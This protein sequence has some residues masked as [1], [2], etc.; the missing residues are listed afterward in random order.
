MTSTLSHHSMSSQDI[1]VPPPRKT[2]GRKRPVTP[3][4]V[5]GPSISL[6]VPNDVSTSTRPLA[7]SSIAGD[8]YT[9][10]A[11]GLLNRFSAAS[12]SWRDSLA[13]LD[14]E[15]EPTV[16][17]VRDTYKRGGMFD[18]SRTTERQ[19][20]SVERRAD[21]DEDEEEDDD[22]DA[23]A[24]KAA[25]ERMRREARGEAV[26]SSQIPSHP[27]TANANAITDS[28]S[29]KTLRVPLPLAPTTRSSSLSSAPP[30]S[31]PSRQP[32]VLRLNAV[33]EETMPVR[34]PGTA[35][36]SGRVGRV[37]VSDDEEDSDTDMGTKTRP[38]R[39]LASAS[40]ESEENEDDHI[41]PL[42]EA[43]DPANAPDAER[44]P[45][46]S[47]FHQFFDSLQDEDRDDSEV[48]QDQSQ[49]AD[50][51]GL[52]DDEELQIKTGKTNIKP[53][54]RK[55]ML[56]M[57]QDM[58][59]A[60]RERD[61]VPSRPEVNR[62]PISS[63]LLSASKV[64]RRDVPGLTHEQSPPTSPSQ[65]T[66][67]DEI[68]SFTPSSNDHNRIRGK[69]SIVNDHSVD[70]AVSSSPTPRIRQVLD[71]ADSTVIPATSDGADEH[72][73]ERIPDLAN[74]LALEDAKREKE[75][76]LKAQAE[77]L[78]R[79]KA[80]ALKAKAERAAATPDDDDD[81]TILPDMQTPRPRARFA[82]TKSPA[83]KAVLQK[84][85]K[86]PAITKQRQDL[87]RR[88]GKSTRTKPSNVTET[89]MDFAGKTWDHAGLRRA[90]GGSRPAGQKSGR[91]AIITTEQ[92]NARIQAG[93]LAQVA[94]YRSQKES[95][96]GRVRQLPEKKVP[97]IQALIEAS[98]AVSRQIEDDREGD[99]SDDEDFVPD[100]EE[101]NDGE[102]EDEVKDVEGAGSALDETEFGEEEGFG[103]ESG[104]SSHGTDKENRPNPIV[105][106]LV[107]EDEEE[108]TPIMKRKPR[109]R[110]ALD[111]DDEEQHPTRLPLEELPVPQAHHETSL[112][113]AGFD[114]GSPGFSQLFEPT[115]LGTATAN[116]GLAE[117]R[118]ADAPGYLAVNALLPGVDITETQIQRDNAL[119]AAEL[120][121]AEIQP[122]LS[123][124]R[125][126]YLNEQ[127][128]F[129]QTKPI[130]PSQPMNLLRRTSTSL[131]E[132]DISRDEDDEEPE[133]TPST[134]EK[135]SSILL[136]SQDSPTQD[137]HSL[138]RLRRR[139]SSP[140]IMPQATFG[141][142]STL[143]RGTNAFDQMMKASLRREEKARAVNHNLIDEQ[144]EE[145]D[146][147][148][149]WAALGGE[150]D[151]ED[152]A[153]EGY[154]P[155]LV[156]DEA[157]DED[158]RKKQDE[159]AAAK[160]REIAEADDAK[161]EAEAKKI[162]EGHYRTKRRG[163]DFYS[164]DED[165]DEHRGKRRKWTKKERR[166]RRLER[167]DGLEKLNGEENAFRQIYEEDLESDEDS[168]VE[169]EVPL[170]KRDR[171]PTP[172][173]QRR[174]GK[175]T[176]AMLRQRARIN[177]ER[178]GQVED[179]MLDQAI[180][181]DGAGFQPA[182]LDEEMPTDVEDEGETQFSIARGTRTVTSFVDTESGQSFAAFRSADTYARYVQEE[183]QTTRRANGT[184]GASVVQRNHGVTG[185]AR[186][187][188][189]APSLLS[190][191]SSQ[192][193]DKL[194][195]PS[196]ADST[197]SGGSILASRSNKFN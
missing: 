28:T 17:P 155:D 107:D 146:E 138:V 22:D 141:G 151:E 30:S 57:K 148:T 67:P 149:G 6:F 69:S 106:Q 121:A 160:A 182:M 16:S 119:I 77:R 14:A 192:M 103:S 133:R 180:G 174:T 163:Q 29:T 82:S 195:P 135:G 81:F 90:N 130:A 134:T 34:R 48:M 87:L 144:A 117:L 19:E 51:V 142:P 137:A 93:H 105:L 63:F 88:A 128:F 92:M 166:K 190:R 136:Q 54:N 188:S 129:T 47:L 165:D 68:A 96:W 99:E 38:Q 24:V 98:A 33:D 43:L 113:L 21:R 75:A 73:D 72:E 50:L 89:Y 122:T 2:Y 55:D 74:V 32:G 115:Q 179:D 111:S 104:Q 158:E 3:P 10:P 175:D 109:I 53:L 120:E 183:S 114:Q 112:D 176:W 196:R 45:A 49:S 123:A 23:E 178:E 20:T 150:E 94:G 27:V 184:A 97:D 62:L 154:V 15:E 110:V 25:M 164:D 66:P 18:F 95:E 1:I 83:A 36:P 91:D 169:D 126:R 139:V 132:I 147:D 102:S 59:R 157:V 153:D 7:S 42:A 9:S 5:D 46:P 64:L 140:V 44:A 100:E 85:T 171:S 152:G 60:Q 70:H 187:S 108:D 11:K 168:T 124:A 61:F 41:A 173:S 127:G 156:D 71:R 84:S 131:S 80:A 12:S 125:P 159:L 65:T 79:A 37:V 58:A 35:G 167:E 197:S 186:G 31:P 143:G 145:S 76:R 162:T 170:D 13:L 116:D 56:L 4:P 39:R 118:G 181:F 86:S 52:F 172:E 189:R 101:E 161:R 8:E 193:A 191:S 26:V 185:G 194:R 177:K 78:N 40:A